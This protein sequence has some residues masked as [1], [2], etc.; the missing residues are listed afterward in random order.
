MYL[1]FKYYT[2]VL[3][4]HD[5]NSNQRCLWLVHFFFCVCSELPRFPLVHNMIFMI[6]KIV[7]GSWMP[8]EAFFF[9]FSFME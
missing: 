4:T 2:I 1:S 8:F 3:K 7:V 6:I 5:E 9:F